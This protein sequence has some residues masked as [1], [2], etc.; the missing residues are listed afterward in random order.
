[1]GF[2]LNVRGA[3]EWQN[4]LKDLYVEINNTNW[5]STTLSGFLNEVQTALDGKKSR[6]VVKTIMDYGASAFDVI[7]VDSSSPITITL[8]LS[9]AR[10]DEVYITD[11]T[12]SAS[13]NNITVN[14]NTRNINGLSENLIMDVD[15]S[16][17]RR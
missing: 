9:A 12:G 10:G 17:V 2:K 6:N 15:M 5:A 4:L 16:S 1:M 11:V 13:T 8:P 3:S 7:L 14:R